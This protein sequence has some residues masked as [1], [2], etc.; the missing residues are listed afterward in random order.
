MGRGE[1]VC[2]TLVSVRETVC[3]SVSMSMN[4]SVSVCVCVHMQ[5]TK[6]T[7]TGRKQQGITNTPT[8]MYV[9]V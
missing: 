5:G 7:C 3:V 6:T 2:G 8:H 1:T 4:M 9:H